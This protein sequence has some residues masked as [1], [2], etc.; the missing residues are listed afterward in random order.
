MLRHAFEIIGVHLFFA[1][2]AS[3]P[4][5]KVVVLAWSAD[6]AAFRKRKRFLVLLVALSDLK[7]SV[8][9]VKHVRFPSFCLFLD[10]RFKFLWGVEHKPKGNVG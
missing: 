7:F 4:V 9:V 8:H 2:V 6:P 3:V 1:T 5:G 10:N